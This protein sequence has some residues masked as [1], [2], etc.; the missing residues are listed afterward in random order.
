MPVIRTD[1]KAKDIMVS[2]P[3]CVEPSTTIRQLAR[4]FEENEISGARWWTRRVE[5]WVLCLRPT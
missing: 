3:V 1:L 2:E 4:V 5:S